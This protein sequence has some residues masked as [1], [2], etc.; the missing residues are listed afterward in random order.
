MFS[1]VSNNT[2]LY[3]EHTSQEY[4]DYKVEPSVS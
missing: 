3:K 2:K 1:V 4:E